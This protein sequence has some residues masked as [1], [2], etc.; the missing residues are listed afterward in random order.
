[1]KGSR[2]FGF[3]PKG[4]RGSLKHCKPG[5]NIVQFVLYQYHSGNRV[6]Y[7]PGLGFFLNSISSFKSHNCS[8]R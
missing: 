3:Y 8:A 2:E 5:L 1:M 6:E 7:V 4:N